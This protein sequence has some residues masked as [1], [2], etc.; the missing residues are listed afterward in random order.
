MQKWKFGFGKAAKMKRNLF[1][2]LETETGTVPYVST[3]HAD[4]DQEHLVWE[5]TVEV[6]NTG[7]IITF[8]VILILFPATV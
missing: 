8:K 5:I 3:I 6:G 4:S 7:H 1:C 2:F